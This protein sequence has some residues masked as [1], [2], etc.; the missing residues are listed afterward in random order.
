MFSW[1]YCHGKAA[2]RVEFLVSSG[3]KLA[4]VACEDMASQSRR[5]LS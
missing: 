3:E 2:V 5:W 4:L 1:K